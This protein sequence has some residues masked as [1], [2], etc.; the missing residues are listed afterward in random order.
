M[1]SLYLRTDSGFREATQDEV[2]AEAQFLIST[3]FHTGSALM[4][5]PRVIGE[6]LRL[7][8]G[9]LDHEIFGILHLDSH[10]R[11]IQ[12]EDLFRGTLDSAQVYARDV[13]QS[14]LTHRS[15]AVV[16]YHNHP[17]GNPTPSFADE[18]LTHRLQKAL[19]LIDVKVLDHFI[20]GET[21]LSFSEQ[22]LL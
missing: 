7:H 8:L 22:G 12:R 2:I 5:N 16:F 20:V 3:R 15:A 1:N 13:L 10:H 21:V 9:P 17:S 4:E 19:A 14:V 6:F 18:E 11:L